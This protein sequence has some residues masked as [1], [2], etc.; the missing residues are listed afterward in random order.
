MRTFGLIGYPLSH[1]FSLS[2]FSDKFRKENIS[3]CHYLNFPIESIR[4]L[5]ALLQQHPTLQ[6]LNVTI[7]Y[8]EQVVVYL[9]S[10][11]DVVNATGACNCI[12]ID[13][14]QQLHGFNTDVEGFEQSLRNQLRPHHTKA[15]ILGTGGAAKAVAFVL[16]KLHI[17]FFF[18][19]RQENKQ[20]TIH[21]DQLSASILSEHLLIINTTPVG[22]YPAE[23]D[24]PPINFTDITARH[25]LFDL[26]Y[27]PAK[28]LFLK[29]GEKRGAAI[30]N[31]YDMLAIQAEESWKIWNEL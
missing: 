27:N 11:N 18:V 9:T 10:K 14:N 1:S 26:I 22:M 12:R 17:S 2:Y 4:E 25:L 3:D 5:P 28:T 21:Y 13:S 30:Q 16:R 20:D 6:G 7:P 29:E 23:N 15:L 24:I 8:K 19:S 31:G